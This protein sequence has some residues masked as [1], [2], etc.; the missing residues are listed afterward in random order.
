MLVCL[1]QSEQ[2]RDHSDMRVDLR[3]GRE[4]QW[5]WGEL[6]IPPMAERKPPKGF[7]AAEEC[8]FTDMDTETQ[9]AG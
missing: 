3:S 6:E 7:G 5:P 2:G 1:E 9:K 8:H 4:P